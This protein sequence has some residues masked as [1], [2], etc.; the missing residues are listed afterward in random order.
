MFLSANIRL[1]AHFTC[2]LM[3]DILIFLLRPVH[4]QHKTPTQTC[5]QGL[6]VM[7]V[8]VQY[9]YTWQGMITNTKYND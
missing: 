1:A 6:I 8:L 3:S 5:A 7:Q 2:G 4:K 9:R